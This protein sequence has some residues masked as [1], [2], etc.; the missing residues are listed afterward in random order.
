VNGSVQVMGAPAG[1]VTPRPDALT[2]HASRGLGKLRR[3][4]LLAIAVLVLGF[5]GL[6]ALLPMAG[7]IMAPGEVAVET[8]VKQISH[9]FGGVVS[10]ILVREGDRVRQGQVLIRLDSKVAGAAAEY[11][12]LSL[13]QMLA[14][15][16]RLRAERDGAGAVNFP[17]EL[18]QRA[19]EP[20]VAA[21]MRDENRAFALSRAARADQIRQLQA[22]IRQVQAEIEAYGSRSVASSSQDRLI[23][24]ELAQT[25][26]LYEGRLTTLDRLNAL[27]R[28]AAGVHADR[29]T[30]AAQI[31]QGRARIGELT[32]QMA[33]VQSTARSQAAT[34]LA[35]VQSLIA[36]IRKQDV[37]ASDQNDRTVIR[38]P[39]A[40][41]V[42]K[43][44]VRTVGGVI[45]AGEPLLEIIP[46]ADRLVVTAHIKLTDID[47]VAI[48]QPAFLRFSALSTRTTPELKGKVTQV[49][50]DRTVDQASGTAFY[51]A[52]V[53]ISDEEFKK[54]E[55]AR[56]TVG[57][58]VEVFIQTGE[59]TI[60]NYILR[61]LG[62]QLNRALRE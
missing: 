4:G 22:Q 56:L 14:R 41:I 49:A 29:A 61:P 13:D 24:E 59:R 51:N 62:D 5:G 21:V 16:A 18:R 12:G 36:D 2:D 60:L 25:R 50:A 38:A 42:D 53:A 32:T 30:A 17:A 20:D 33:A 9:P 8:H 10:E 35:Q 55:G 47:Q 26:E 46:A 19:G 34:A 6:M 40:G 7:A 39:Q 11:T 37:A 3:I 23:N 52:T 31:D 44:A 54:L 58:P 45:P 57:M 43:L 1:W 15:E 28:A 27:E 48:G